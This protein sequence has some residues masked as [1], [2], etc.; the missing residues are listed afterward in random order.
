MLTT[1]VIERHK[2]KFLR[3]NRVFVNWASNEFGT[4]EG[5]VDCNNVVSRRWLEWLGFE[6]V[7][8]D[9]QYMRMQYGN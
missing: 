1:P 7:N 3:L 8:S 4:I 6:L 2:I 9:G 5:C